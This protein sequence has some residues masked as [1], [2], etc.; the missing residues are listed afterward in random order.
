MEICDQ[1]P[2]EKCS[3]MKTIW[4]RGEV[5]ARKNEEIMM[6]CSRVHAQAAAPPRRQASYTSVNGMA[7]VNGPCSGESR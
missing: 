4:P 3:L 6:A 5:A 1:V 2:E 7:A